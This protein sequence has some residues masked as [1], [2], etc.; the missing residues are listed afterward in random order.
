MRGK[1][2]D[3]RDAADMSTG[4]LVESTAE[5]LSVLSRSFLDRPDDALATAA[6]KICTDAAGKLKG[7]LSP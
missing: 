2:V 3:L 7:L 5:A 6:T 4:E 1:D